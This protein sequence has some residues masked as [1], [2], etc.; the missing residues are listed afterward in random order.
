MN[1]TIFRRFPRQDSGTRA[2]GVECDGRRYFVKEAIRP[3]TA[4]G[5][6]RAE[7]LNRHF[8]HPILPFLRNT[9]RTPD[10]L[11]GVYDWVDAEVIYNVEIP[12]GSRID[13]ADSPHLRFRSL[14]LPR[15]LH[16]LDQVFHAH[17]KLALLGY[18]ASDFYDGAILYDFEG[19]RTYLCDQDEYRP[20]SFFLLTDRNFGSTRF[21]APE[22][23]KKGAVI[24]EVTNV[25][26]TGRTA[27]VLLGN[28]TGS[29]AGFRGSREM[30]AV[31]RRATAPEREERFTSLAEFARAWRAA[32]PGEGTA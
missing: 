22:E 5:I 14:P 21:M 28:G 31:A 6:L 3:E 23:F 29:E 10:G 26:T 30:L 19:H 24:D 1:G 13:G 17:E 20:G 12:R 11:V 15:V 2:F 27:L 7:E 25:F 9:I 8:R 16:A 4:A 32:A 18:V